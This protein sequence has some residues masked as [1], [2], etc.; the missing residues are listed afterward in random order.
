MSENDA[1]L[2]AF[3]EWWALYGSRIADARNGGTVEFEAFA[4]GA[5]WQRERDAQVVEGY[6]I[7]YD[8]VWEQQEGPKD[9]YVGAG[10]DSVVEHIRTGGHA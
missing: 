3:S 10:L 6:Y 5:E 2:N 4:A 1:V 8:G 7:G 9:K